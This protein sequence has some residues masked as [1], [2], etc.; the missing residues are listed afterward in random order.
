MPLLARVGRRSWK[1]RLLLSLIYFVLTAGAITTAYPFWVMVCGSI[2]SNHM[3]SEL[4]PVPRYLYS[5]RGLFE[6]HIYNKYYRYL[7]VTDLEWQWKM[8]FPGAYGSQS[9]WQQLPGELPTIET[10]AGQKLVVHFSVDRYDAFLRRY[11]SLGSPTKWSPPLADLVA[12]LFPFAVEPIKDLLQH[13]DDPARL[14]RHAFINV[15]QSAFKIRLQQFLN[16]Y[17]RAGEPQIGTD[18][19][20]QLTAAFAELLNDAVFTATMRQYEICRK[21]NLTDPRVVQRLN[22]FVHFKSSLPLPF[23]DCYWIGSISRTFKGDELYRQFVRDKYG[24]VETLNQTYH[25]DL[26]DVV[27]LYAPYD[28]PENR[29]TYVENT[30]I[31]RDWWEWKSQQASKFIRPA[32]IEYWWSKA[33]EATYGGSIEHLNNAY[34]TRHLT[35]FDVSLPATLPSVDPARSDWSRFVRTRLPARYISFVDADALW[36]KFLL[37][38]FGS[39]AKLNDALHRHWSSATDIRL[40]NLQDNPT[41]NPPTRR[42]NDLI[43][44]FLGVVPLEN[45]CVV[46]PE[47]LYRRWLIEHYGSIDSINRAYG[48]RASAVEDLYLPLPMLDWRELT[49]N[50]AETRWYTFVRSYKTAINHL[51]RHRHSLWNTAILCAGVVLGALIVNPLCAYA[52]SRFELPSSNKVLLFLLGTMAFPVEITMIPNFL[53]LKA[54]P[55]LRITCGLA[56]LAICGVAGFVMLSRRHARAPVIAAIAGAILGSTLLAGAVSSF[57]SVPQNISLLNTFWALILPGVAS[58]YSIFLLK[59][60]FDS[61]PQELYESAVIDGAGELRIF[62]QITMPLSTPVLAVIALW[63]FTAAYGSFAWALVVCQDPNMWTLMVHLY[64]YQMQV[65]PSE[66][67]AALVLASLPTLLV[68]IVAQKVILR[69]I[70]IPTSK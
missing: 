35:F 13:A 27:Q 34:G 44:Q 28:H 64:Q 65:D 19:F 48:S 11:Q 38:Q 21:P 3:V 55:L 70:V 15:L 57:A 31:N 16:A 60:F 49:D 67:L 42:E 56:G 23:R 33:L 2:A 36:A 68:F 54:F 58:G 62:A 4:S 66:R 26:Q 22:D 40:P 25:M 5:E 29:N 50:P 30:A 61:L 18:Q 7:P 69:G 12:D 45:V 52:L 17:Q 24:T 20:E 43:L 59:G 6:S 10:S 9:V 37:E 8:D 51:T 32:A 47:V 63:S 53:L 39:L 41:G 14:D 46:T 1:V